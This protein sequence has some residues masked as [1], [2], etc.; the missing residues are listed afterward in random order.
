MGAF[1][2]MKSTNS[3]LAFGLPSAR[4]H[5]CT[6]V[7]AFDVCGLTK[8]MVFLAPTSFINTNINNNLLNKVGESR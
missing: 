5:C 8:V 1:L 2:Y 3:G 7:F 4:P 6:L